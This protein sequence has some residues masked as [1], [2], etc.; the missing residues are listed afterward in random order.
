M[1]REK[2]IGILTEV[3]QYR[4]GEYVD[5]K[6]D[7][8]EDKEDFKKFSDEVADAILSAV[9]EELPKE[10]GYAKGLV[11]DIGSVLMGNTAEQMKTGFEDYKRLK[12]IESERNI[13]YNQALAEIR[14]ILK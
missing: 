7:S 6:L 11:E 5:M 2:I 1:L 14:E 9:L 12:E 8:E 3:V 4:N 13:G 10:D